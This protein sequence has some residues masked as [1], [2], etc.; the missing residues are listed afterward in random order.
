MIFSARLAISDPANQ[1]IEGLPF[2]YHH[3]C[4]TRNGANENR[5]DVKNYSF[6]KSPL[7]YLDCNGYR[8][9]QPYDPYWVTTDTAQSTL[10]MGSSKF[11]G[12][13]IIKSVDH[14]RKQVIA[15]PLTFGIP[16]LLGL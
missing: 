8:Y 1:L 2:S 7:I 14:A 11:A 5:S 10:R 15:S 13:G 9:I 12:I 4:R 6:E 3:Q 16:D